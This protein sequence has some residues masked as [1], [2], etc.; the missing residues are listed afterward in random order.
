MAAAETLFFFFFS[1]FRPPREARTVQAAAASPSP[2][3]LAPREEGAKSEKASPTGM[4]SL[5][6]ERG[7]AQHPAGLDL[8][9]QS[10]GEW[11]EEGEGMTGTP[12][13]THHV[14]LGNHVDAGYVDVHPDADGRT[15]GQSTLGQPGSRAEPSRAE[16]GRA[17]QP[18]DKTGGMREAAAGATHLRNPGGG[19]CR[20]PSAVYPQFL[21]R[22]TCCRDRSHCGGERDGGGRG[23]G[24]GAG[25]GAEPIHQ[26]GPPPPGH[27]ASYLWAQQTTATRTGAEKIPKILPPPKP[28]I[29]PPR[30]P[31]AQQQQPPPP[32]P[33]SGCPGCR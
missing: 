33:R 16:P 4:E 7:C 24:W 14:D 28:H 29:P 27:A 5:E 23:R 26:R 11:G 19:G 6:T 9:G 30:A 18:R 2:A 3:L 1:A 13:L 10:G 20:S 12:S 32:P 8:P 15:C 31:S 25:R 17:G 21:S 22:R